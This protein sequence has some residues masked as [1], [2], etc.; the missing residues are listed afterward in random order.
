M[1]VYNNKITFA[2]LDLDFHFLRHS[3][4]TIQPTDKFVSGWERIQGEINRGRKK[5]RLQRDLREE[6]LNKDTEP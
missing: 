5:Y 2:P 1:A 3:P 6:N 4:Q